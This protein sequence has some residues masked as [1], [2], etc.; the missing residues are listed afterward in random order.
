MNMKPLLIFIFLATVIASPLAY[1]QLSP[2]DP[3][4]L[5]GTTFGQS[6]NDERDLANS[7]VPGP[8]KYGKGEKKQLVSAADLK[9]KSL[10]DSTFGGSLLDMGIPSTNEP[11]LDETKLHSAPTEGAANA[12][13]EKP[14][15]TEKESN[16]SK[17]TATVQKE[18][19]ASTEPAEQQPVF[20]NMSTTAT[21]AENLGEA[22]VAA[23]ESA[24]QSKT[25]SSSTATSA[26][27]TADAPKK[28]QGGATTS[29]DKSSTTKPDG[30]H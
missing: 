3:G 2:G 12:S 19:S 13:K 4:V 29:T 24:S 16:V 28:D 15:T 8:Q 1:G 5:G 9:S 6:N 20:S 17:Q 10:K 23:A 25:S 18:P 21:L 30:D 7:L 11:K 26:T 22:D 27:T 14:A